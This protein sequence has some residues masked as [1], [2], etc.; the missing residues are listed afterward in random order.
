M[1]TDAPTQDDPE[2][3]FSYLGQISTTVK[4]I[5]E[6]IENHE[7]TG[8]T[9]SMNGPNC[10]CWAKHFLKQLDPQLEDSARTECQ[11]RGLFMQCTSQCLRCQEVLQFHL[12][13]PE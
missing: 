11:K 12:L 6:I 2:W 5:Y 13:Y 3:E 9:Y 8:E 4:T 7:L 10:Q 1:K